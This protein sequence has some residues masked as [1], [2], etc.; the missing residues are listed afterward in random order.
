MLPTIP[1]AVMTTTTSTGRTSVK[2]QHHRHTKSLRHVKVHGKRQ[3]SNDVVG[4]TWNDDMTLRELERGTSRGLCSD[5]EARRYEAMLLQDPLQCLLPRLERSFWNR[6]STTAKERIGWCLQE[7]LGNRSWRFIGLTCDLPLFQEATTGLLF[8]LIPGGTYRRGMSLAAKDQLLHCLLTYHG[9]AHRHDLPRESF[10]VQNALL[11]IDRTETGRDYKVEPFL[12]ATMPIPLDQATRVLPRHDQEN[13]RVPSNVITSSSSSIQSPFR[14]RLPTEGEWEYAARGGGWD[15]VFPYQCQIVST[16]PTKDEMQPRRD[17]SSCEDPRNA[18]GLRQVGVWPELCL[19]EADDENENDDNRV[20]HLRTDAPTLV[21]RSGS[22][23]WSLIHHAHPVRSG[24]PALLDYTFV[25]D[26]GVHDSMMITTNAESVAEK[27]VVR[28]AV[29][30]C[31][32]T[33]GNKGRQE[34]QRCD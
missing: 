33:K 17:R 27:E 16:T 4:D 8:T 10:Q 19:G 3:R 15:I 2:D 21:A 26:V 5:Q 1:D 6:L 12:L 11:L 20:H 29:D 31:C 23:M 34:R 7:F 30:I 22:E 14:F 9:V 18:L 28:L 24:H 32:S 13:C 25:S